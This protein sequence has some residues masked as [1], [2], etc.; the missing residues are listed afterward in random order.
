[1]RSESER[2]EVCDNYEQWFNDKLSQ[3]DPAVLNEPRKLW[4]LGKQ[5]G[6]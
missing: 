6:F 3:Q 1:M 5:Q 2:D 4:V